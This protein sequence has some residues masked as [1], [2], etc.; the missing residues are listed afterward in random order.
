MKEDLPINLEINIVSVFKVRVGVSSVHGVGLFSVLALAE[1][2][3]ICG[4][5]PL[6][7]Y[8]KSRIIG[9]PHSI[10]NILGTMPILYAKENEIL[11]PTTNS[12][13]P[14]YWFMNHSIKPNIYFDGE[15]FRA[16][17]VVSANS[18]LFYNYATL[19]HHED[20]LFK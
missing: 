13:Q 3:I 6:V 17:K 11:I 14:T 16:L 19:D 20:F 18:E 8:P 4:I 10:K 2:E 1:D 12:I 9:L 15:F 7:R 5:E